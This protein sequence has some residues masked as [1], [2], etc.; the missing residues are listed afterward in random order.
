MKKELDF[1]IY[2]VG[3]AN[4]TIIVKD[5]NALV[6]DCGATM[7]NKWIN[8]KAFFPLIEDY[9]KIIF[10]NVK[11][12]LVIISHTDRDHMNFF[13]FKKFLRNK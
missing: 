3:Q 12:F 13:G 11:K 2:Y 10:K 1:N 6:Y 4:F 8:G 5:E 7:K 9:L